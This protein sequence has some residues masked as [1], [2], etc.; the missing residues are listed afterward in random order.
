MRLSNE[1][2]APGWNEKKYAACLKVDV[3]F[4]W[5]EIGEVD[6]MKSMK[7]Y[8][9]IWKTRRIYIYI[10]NVDLDIWCG[11]LEI[12]VSLMILDKPLLDKQKDEN[13]R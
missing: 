12:T 2:L 5:E 10:T 4:I 13:R 9:I 8:S 11:N 1:Y 6:Q 7:H 3:E